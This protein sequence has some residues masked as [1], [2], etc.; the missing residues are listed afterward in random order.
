M[1]ATEMQSHRAGGA[2]PMREVHDWRQVHGKLIELARRKAG[3]DAEESRWLLAGRAA[4]VH[5]ECGYGSYLE[6]LERVFGYGPRLA[7]ERLRVAG[8]LARLPET[9]AALAAGELSWSAIREISR[10]AT[11]DTEAD[12]IATARNRTVRE[13]EDMVSGRVLGDRPGDPPRPDQRMHVLRL[14]LGATTYA[15]FRQL[16]E[17]VTREAGHSLTDDEAMQL[18]CGRALSAAPAQ[19]SAGTDPGEAEREGAEIDVNSAENDTGPSHDRSSDDRSAA[20][21][22][23]RARDESD[24]G[25]HDA[26][27]AR[28]QI[29]RGRCVECER[30]WQEG[31]GRPIEIDATTFEVSDC[32]A[33]YLGATHGGHGAGTERASQSTPPATR[34][35]AVRR[36][37]GRCEV[38]GCRHSGWIDVHHIRFRSQGGTHELENLSVLCSVHHAHVHEGR[39]R[40]AGR[41]PSLRF[42]HADGRPYGAAINPPDPQPA[43]EV[44]IE[45]TDAS[46][47]TDATSALTNLGFRQR[48]AAS[49]LDAAVHAL[50]GPTTLEALLR[51][52]LQHLRTSTRCRE[53]QPVWQ[54]HGE[55]GRA[56]ETEANWARFAISISSAPPWRHG[57]AVSPPTTVSR[58]LHISAWEGATSADPG[59]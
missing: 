5:L 14:E 58:P 30:M 40:I 47:L 25:R 3:Y 11:P 7:R 20:G 19:S 4:N 56:L 12:W 32:D 37:Y 43:T 35:T 31:G 48:E 59:R 16:V 34:R 26:G 21:E 10:V 33:Q 24:V 9:M 54:T 52:S 36:A 1:Q 17:L 53:S 41:Q 28:Y 57:P 46:L 51:E 38:P 45:S 15:A 42:F 44:P 23:E 18:I 55:A 27:R 13:V 22:S 2:S 49:A 29:V 39:L 6:Y 50:P 8:A